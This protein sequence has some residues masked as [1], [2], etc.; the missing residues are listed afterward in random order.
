MA[1]RDDR[2][3]DALFRAHATA[4]HR[5]FTRRCPTDDVQDLAAEV[6]TIA[7]RRRTELPDG[8]HLPWLYRTAGF[9]LANYRRKTRAIP[10]AEIPH[11]PDHDADPAA[12]VIN[13]FQVRAALTELSERDRQI[14]LLA[15]W[16]GLRGAEL[17]A[18]LGISR[19]GADAALS[20][21]RARFQAAWQ[22]VAAS[23]GDLVT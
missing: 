22:Q 9:V 6:F 19:G 2:W 12:V 5:Y 10:V 8:A 18:V 16:E 13:D 17:A 15:A 21:A 4:I 1:Q 7:W 11:E 20:R 23:S 3:F 14:L